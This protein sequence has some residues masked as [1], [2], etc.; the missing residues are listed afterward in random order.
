MSNIVVTPFAA[1]QLVIEE[2]NNS[3]VLEINSPPSIALS[4]SGPQGA[5]GPLSDI[6]KSATISSPQPND[7]F[8]LF[9]TSRLTTI[10]SVVSLVSGS[11]PSVA[12]ELRFASNR[13]TAGLVAASGVSTS[14][15]VGDTGTIVNS[16]IPGN[17]FVWLKINAVSGVVHDFNVTMVY[18]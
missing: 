2:E 3:V 11:S 16:S 17:N 15:T 7:S 18:F 8:T 10:N 1:N 13:G 6:P 14:Q 5:I 9:Y 4:A 12:Y